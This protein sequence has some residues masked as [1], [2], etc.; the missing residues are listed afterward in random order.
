M[1]QF[2]KHLVMAVT[3]ILLV[4]GS[5]F[6]A[7]VALWGS[8]TCQKRFLEPGAKALQAATGVKIK[9]FGVGTGKGMV[10]L[11]DGKTNVSITSNNLEGTIKSTQKVLKK[12][13]KP[14]AKI[15]ENIQFHEITKDIIVPIVNKSNP[16]ASLTW[17]QLAGLN[18]GK[19][20]NWKDVGG[21]DE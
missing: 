21:N 6:A 20:T 2:G 13:G 19:I 16:V 9:V 14:A 3:I 11:L 1:K 12:D 5:A 4:A 15:P 8:T 17:A 10:A 18:T 7:D